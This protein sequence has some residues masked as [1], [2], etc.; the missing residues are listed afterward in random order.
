MKYSVIVRKFLIILW[1]KMKFVAVL[2]APETSLGLT[3]FRFM[4]ETCRHLTPCRDSRTTT[5]IIFLGSSY[6]LCRQMG[7]IWRR[8]VRVRL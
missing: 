5:F 8:S 6:R 1:H 3:A 2:M 4:I 7:I